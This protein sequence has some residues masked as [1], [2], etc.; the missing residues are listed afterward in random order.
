MNGP[1]RWVL[2][3]TV[4]IL[5]GAAIFAL[6]GGLTPELIRAVATFAILL[7]AAVALY[8]VGRR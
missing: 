8:G 4:I 7:I 1:L 3:F 6:W 2:F 5:A